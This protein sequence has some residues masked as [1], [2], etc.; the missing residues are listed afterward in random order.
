MDRTMD[1]PCPAP[2][3]PAGHDRQRP[4]S[5]D[6]TR[7]RIDSRDRARITH[8]GRGPTGHRPGRSGPAN[9]C[10]FIYLNPR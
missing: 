9:L 2:D 7:F 8:E 4:G 6:G 1:K 10:S 5:D 3:T